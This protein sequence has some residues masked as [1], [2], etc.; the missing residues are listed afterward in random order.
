MFVFYF[1]LFTLWYTLRRRDLQHTSYTYKFYMLPLLR[2]DLLL[3]PTAPKWCASS[4]SRSE[5]METHGLQLVYSYTR[6]QW[7]YQIVTSI[8]DTGSHDHSDDKAQTNT[9][10]GYPSSSLWSWGGISSA[11]DLTPIGEDLN[12][13]SMQQLLLVKGKSLEFVGKIWVV[14]KINIAFRNQL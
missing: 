14:R 5:T 9:S 6:S 2:S 12:V 4:D 7:Q 3:Q 10:C 8:I 11:D 1:L 13:G